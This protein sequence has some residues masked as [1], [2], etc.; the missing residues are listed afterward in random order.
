MTSLYPF[1]MYAKEYLKGNK[2]TTITDPDDQVISSYFGIAAIVVMTYIFSFLQPRDVFNSALVCQYWR[3][4]LTNLD[5]ADAP[6]FGDL[7]S[8]GDIDRIWRNLKRGSCNNTVKGLLR[9]PCGC[10][11]FHKS[12]FV[13]MN[14]LCP[15]TANL[16]KCMIIKRML[17]KMKRKTRMT[18]WLIHFLRR[19]SFLT[20]ITSNRIYPSGSLACMLCIFVLA[21]VM[22]LMMIIMKK[23]SIIV[24]KISM[25]IFVCR[26]RLHHFLPVPS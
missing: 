14:I 1:V 24:L 11:E 12:Y 9:S 22:N 17:I 16:V 25:F 6:W 26:H 4:I 3:S 18:L 13:D 7:R 5:K 20:E 10:T 19:G 8:Y 21:S 15:S 23:S 2:P